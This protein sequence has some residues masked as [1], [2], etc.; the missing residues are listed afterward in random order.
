MTYYHIGKFYINEDN[1]DEFEFG[2]DSFMCFFSMIKKSYKDN[3]KNNY[4]DEMNQKEWVSGIANFEPSY[5]LFFFKKIED[6]D[7]EDI[8]EDLNQVIPNCKDFHSLR[9]NITDLGCMELINYLASYGANFN[10][11]RFMGLTFEEAIDSHILK[12]KQIKDILKTR[13]K[14]NLDNYKGKSAWQAYEIIFSTKY[15][16]AFFPAKTEENWVEILVNGKNF[17]ALDLILSSWIKFPPLEIILDD[18]K[19][20]KVSIKELIKIEDQLFMLN[21]I[22]KLSRFE[23]IINDEY[24]ENFLKL[25]N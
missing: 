13:P 24:H 5:L 16:A 8:I 11:H 6:G 10:N 23:M 20:Q 4:K 3:K 9:D 2:Y 19:L 18:L 14:I 7:Y 21:L 15:G 12:F 22:E 25:I 1:L 17:E